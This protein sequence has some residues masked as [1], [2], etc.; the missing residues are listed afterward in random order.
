MISFHTSRKHVVK[1]VVQI[2]EHFWHPHWGFGGCWQELLC[3]SLRCAELTCFPLKDLLML[4]W[5]MMGHV[6]NRPV[7]LESCDQGFEHI[8]DLIHFSFPFIGNKIQEKGL[9]FDNVY[10]NQRSFPYLFFLNSF[11]KVHVYFCF[12]IVI[13]LICHIKECHTWEAAV[14]FSGFNV[15]CP[16]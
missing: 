11:F 2:H 9:Y 3:W 5:F 13:V 6:L 12:T 10:L 14:C 8:A 1:R 16:C 15:L 4:I 7:L